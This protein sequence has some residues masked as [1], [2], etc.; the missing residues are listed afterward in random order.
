[1]WGILQCGCRQGRRQQYQEEYE[2]GNAN[3]NV[4]R[5]AGL[6]QLLPLIVLLALTFFSFGGN[7]EALFR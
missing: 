2:D 4:N 3:V 5:F 1:V 6:I 7:E